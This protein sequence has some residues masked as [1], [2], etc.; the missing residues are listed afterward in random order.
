[1]AGSPQSQQSIT[2]LG[3]HRLE[4]RQD[5]NCYTLIIHA[6]TLG[7]GQHVYETVHLWHRVTLCVE[8]KQV[9]MNT[10]TDSREH[11]LAGASIPLLPPTPVLQEAHSSHPCYPLPLDPQAC[12]SSVAC[13]LSQAD[14]CPQGPQWSFVLYPYALPHVHCQTAHPPYTPH[15]PLSRLLEVVPGPAC[16][17]QRCSSIRS[18]CT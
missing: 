3:A 9:R 16:S 10:Y 6:A 2:Y 18:P 1:M 13:S 11:S 12:V 4:A 8:Q 17:E 14:S 5:T 15:C 7:A